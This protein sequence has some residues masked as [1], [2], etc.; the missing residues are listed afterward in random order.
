MLFAGVMPQPGVIDQGY[1]D[2][3]D[4]IVRLLAAHHIW[5]LLDFHQDAFNER[6]AGE[7]FPDWAT[8]D[9]GLPFVDLG[10]FFLND[11][12]PAVQR[13]YDHLW[14]NTGGLWRSYAQAWGAVA[15][16]WRNQPYLMGYDLINEPN[17][18]TQMSTCANPAGCPAFDATLQRFY[19]YVRAAIRRVDAANLVWYEPQ[20]LFNAIS[21]SN[22]GPVDD[23]QVGLS[24]HDYACTPA[25]VEGGVFPGDPDC[26][27]NE[28]R[29]MD[30]AEQQMATMGAAGVM[31]EFGAGDDL[32][33]LARLTTYADDHLTGWMYWAYKLWDDPTGNR[34]EGLFHDDADLSSVKHDK[35]ALLSR[36]YAQAVAGTPTSLSWDADARVLTVRYTPRPGTGR[37]NVFVPAHTYPEGYEVRVR[38]GAVTGGHGTSHVLVAAGRHAGTVTIVVSPRR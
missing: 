13:A 5:V 28:P 7:G 21:A 20:F 34:N 25:F 19:E 3:I 35:L 26:T 18:G 12:T 4:R 33:D 22:F 38:G 17:A 31:S 32:E 11:Q 2:H 9:D 1:L 14:D 16:R 15:R 23:P 24:W 37:T 36:P 30:N 27:I 29:V 8:H 6:F 10:N